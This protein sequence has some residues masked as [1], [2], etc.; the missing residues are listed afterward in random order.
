[1]K[2]V[3]LDDW[4]KAFTNHPALERLSKLGEVE[5]Y[6]EPLSFNQL[7]RYPK[8]SRYCLAYTRKDEIH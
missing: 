4:N 2:I 5:L 7:N 1:M 3:I 6:Q 8:Y